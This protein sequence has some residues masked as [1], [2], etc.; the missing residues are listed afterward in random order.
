MRRA[1][2]RGNAALLRELQNVR[3]LASSSGDGYDHCPATPGRA[4]VRPMAASLSANRRLFLA[5]HPAGDISTMTMVTSRTMTRHD[6]CID[7][8]QRS[9]GI[10]A[11]AHCGRPSLDGSDAC[12]G[13]AGSCGQYD[14]NNAGA[15]THFLPSAELSSERLLTIPC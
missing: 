5:S 12:A 6:L 10:I 11:M 1:W 2:K 9:N 3:A 4:T 7:L 15:F 14:G 8:L 13:T